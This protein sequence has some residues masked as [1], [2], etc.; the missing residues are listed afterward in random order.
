MLAN[1]GPR[2]NRKVR[3]PVGWV[4]IDDLCSGDVRWHQ[5]RRELDAAELHPQRL[6]ERG[7]G[8]RLCQPRNADCQAMAPSKQADEH[9]LD[10]LILA[11]DH[12]VDFL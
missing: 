8:E 6:G 3:L 5:V 4:L 12:L 2:T 11:N 1:T 9:L 7:H 10:H